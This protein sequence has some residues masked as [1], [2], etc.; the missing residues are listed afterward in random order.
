[1]ANILSSIFDFSSESVCPKC[2]SHDIEIHYVPGGKPYIKYFVAPPPKKIIICNA[3]GY[4][5]NHLTRA[6]N[7]MN[8]NA[9]IDMFRDPV[10]P[11]PGSI[12]VCDL[13]PF[14]GAHQIGAGAEHSGVYA[15]ENTI[16]HRN[17]NGYIE[18]TTPKKFLDRLDGFNC[19]V[20]IYVACKGTEAFDSEDCYRRAL[21]ALDDKEQ[22][23]YDILNKNCHHFTRYCLT[24]DTDQWGLDFTFSSLQN[25]LI[26]E[27]QVDNWRMWEFEK[28]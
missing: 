2:G 7:S 5:K 12:V 24:G 1:M 13:S 16:I 19:A 21:Q 14:P 25:L 11:L 18:K 4:G 22:Q 23:G 26:D 20:S 10:E 3:C 8:R 27:F 17:G 15:G 9:F 28:E 6:T